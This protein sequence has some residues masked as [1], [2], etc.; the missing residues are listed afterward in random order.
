MAKGA[1]D[2][3][4]AIPH[5][6]A[7]RGYRLSKPRLAVI[8]ALAQATE[9]MTVAALHAALPAPRAH[10]VS[11]YRAVNLLVAIGLLRATHLGREGRQEARYELNEQFT[12]HH[13]HLICHRCGRMEDLAGCVL[14]D[15]ALAGLTRLVQRTRRFQV[16]EHELR[17][18]G[19]C[20]RCAQ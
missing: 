10:I 19:V 6:L 17:L 16:T 14:P 20:H 11:L 13:H 18:F 3:A 2:P 5:L 4:V 8:R 9:P 7:R 12:G 15:S 1:Q